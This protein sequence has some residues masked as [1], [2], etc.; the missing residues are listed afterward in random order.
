MT[1]TKDCAPW[2]TYVH[3]DGLRYFR[4]K[5]GDDNNH[6]FTYLTEENLFSPSA[7]EEV[8]RFISKLEKD[9]VRFEGRLPDDDIEAVLTIET[10]VPDT[11]WQ[12]YLVSLGS[13]ELSWLHDF[14]A[15]WI[16]NSIDGVENIQQLSKDI[17]PSFASMNLTIYTCFIRTLLRF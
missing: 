6:H 13:R 2:T 17:Y 4:W 3:P 9:A 11:P 10:K 14:D 12:S 16:V 7:R 15:S 5:K 8:N 1:R